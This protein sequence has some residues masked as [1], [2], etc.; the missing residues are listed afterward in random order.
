MSINA[1]H[2]GLLAEGLDCPIILLE[3]MAGQG[4]Q[5]GGRFEELGF[6]IGEQSLPVRNA[7]EVSK[8]DYGLSC[9]S[10]GHLKSKCMTKQKSASVSTRLMLS[11]LASTFGRKRDLRA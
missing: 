4:K 6:V 9:C 2:A 10:A 11:P 5:V 8:A 1:A 3:N 7:E